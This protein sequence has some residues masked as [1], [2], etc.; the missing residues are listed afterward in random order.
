M[1]KKVCLFTGG[2]SG[3]HVIPAKA[4]LKELLKHPEL[5][6]VYVGSHGGIER[7]IVQSLGI[8]YYAIATGKLRRSLSVQ[9]IVLNL[10]D[11]FLVVAGFFSSLR[12]LWR[13]DRKHS[14]V[15]SMGGFVSVPV[16]LAASVL[17]IPL[18]IHEQTTRAGL[19]NRIAGLVAQKIFLSFPSSL[20]LF[21]KGKTKVVGY[22]VREGLFGKAPPLG[23]DRPVLFVTGGGN[24]SALLNRFVFEN[25]KE[26]TRSF[27]V[28]HQTGP[29]DLPQAQ[30]HYRPH[31]FLDDDDYVVALKGAQVVL[32]R[33]GAG[34]VAELLCLGKRGLLVPLKSAQRSEQLANALWAQKVLGCPIIDEE[35]FQHPP[36]VLEIIKNFRPKVDQALAWREN[37]RDKILEFILMDGS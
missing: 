13:L 9:S 32:S 5:R 29:K 30:A 3:G 35:D 18:Y 22:P 33:A 14:L 2:G 7:A 21:P 23:I 10:R 19:A 36:K 24:G 27:Y 20:P 8:T 28:I 16:A 15:M 26:L 25:L 17:R 4:L 11:A 31:D 34:T 1:P 12:L 37:P 6:L